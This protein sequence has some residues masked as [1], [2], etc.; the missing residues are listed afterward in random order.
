MSAEYQSL[1]LRLNT[2]FQAIARAQ[3]AQTTGEAIANLVWAV[4]FIA[5]VS[6]RLLTDAERSQWIDQIENDANKGANL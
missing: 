6:D 4:Q 5:E 3:K 2:A 1:R